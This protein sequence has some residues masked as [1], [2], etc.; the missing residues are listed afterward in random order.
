MS[1]TK[2]SEREQARINAALRKQ[3]GIGA[4]MQNMSPNDRWRFANADSKKQDR[5]RAIMHN[6][7]KEPRQ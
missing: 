3:G 4:A 1:S 2:L 5:L 6:E 7:D